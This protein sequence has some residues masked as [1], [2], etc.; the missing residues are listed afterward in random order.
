MVLDVPEQVEW[1]QRNKLWAQD[2]ATW[3]GYFADKA[4]DVVT[5]Q[6]MTSSVT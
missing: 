6:I 2:S 1:G 4:E 3:R 5:C